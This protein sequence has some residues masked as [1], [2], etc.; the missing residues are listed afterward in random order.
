MKKVVLVCLMTCYVISGY[1]QIKKPFLFRWQDKSSKKHVLKFVD[2]DTLLAMKESTLH[3][4][5]SNEPSKPYLLMLHGMGANART[6]LSSQVKTLSGK[7]NLILPDL[8]YF[9]ESNSASEDYSVEFQVEQIHQGLLKLGIT[10]SLHVMGFSY[11]G[12]T[13]ATYNQLYPDKI[14]KLII[15]DG[16]VKFFSG[17]MADSLAQ[18][19]G[20]SNINNVI[21]PTTLTEFNGMTRAVMSRSFPVTKKLKQK[22]LTHF[23]A[24]HKAIRDKQINY[25]ME[26]QK[27]YQ[28]Y[29]YNLHNTPT[30]LIWG[31]KDGAVPVSVGKALHKAFPQT[32]QLLIFPKAR[33]DVHFRDARKVNKAIINFIEQ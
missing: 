3:I 31:E 9:G 15:I 5:Y 29:N 8:I 26:H 17:E 4:T 25:L 33:H 20:V 32:T 24:P 18:M 11:G 22:I 1:S 28:N 14:K 12:L 16:P 10:D 30:L 7:F 27:R 13:A 21:V 2:H 23:F 19:V 6:N